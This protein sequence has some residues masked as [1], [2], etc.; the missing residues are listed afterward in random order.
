[1]VK[2]ENTWGKIAGKESIMSLSSPYGISGKDKECKS[3]IYWISTSRA[4]I[5]LF[6]E[7]QRM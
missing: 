4:R 1:M 7:S 3:L 2:P 6:L 5:L